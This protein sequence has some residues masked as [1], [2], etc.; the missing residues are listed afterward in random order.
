MKRTLLVG[1]VAGA[2]LLVGCGPTEVEGPGMPEATGEAAAAASYDDD[3]VVARLAD[4]LFQQDMVPVVTITSSGPT[5]TW[6]CDW[7][8]WV[9]LSVENL[10]YDKTVGLI[11][12]D[13]GWQTAQVSYAQYEA[14]L[15]SG[16][17]RW[18]LN[19]TGRSASGS[20]P[21]IEYAAFAEMNGD[22]YY[23]KE[24]NWKNYTLHP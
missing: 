7:G 17:E 24:D 18:G 8:Y 11:W 9:D 19:L 21:I 20:P 12:T 6:Y 5:T 14:D 15:G 23:G 16:Y 13:D 10:A 3:T 22:T 4:G 1:I 2:G